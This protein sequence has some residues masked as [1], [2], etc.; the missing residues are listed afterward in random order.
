MI[1]RKGE[2]SLKYS[3]MSIFN[4]LSMIEVSIRYNEICKLYMINRNNGF[5][6]LMPLKRPTYILALHFIF[7]FSFYIF[8]LFHNRLFLSGRFYRVTSRLIHVNEFVLVGALIIG[9]NTLVSKVPNYRLGSL[10]NR[11]TSSIP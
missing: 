11:G 10:C 7:F 8:S 6:L 9:C 1:R 3:E 5:S 4:S 2:R